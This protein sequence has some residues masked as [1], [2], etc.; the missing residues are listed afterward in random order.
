MTLKLKQ[1]RAEGPNVVLVGVDGRGPDE[2]ELAHALVSV[3]RDA[4]TADDS[5]FSRL[6]MRDR[7]AF[8]QYYER[9]AAVMV[10]TGPSPGGG[11]A[12]WFNPRARRQVETRGL[13]ALLGALA[14]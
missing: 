8:F 9:L 2:Q 10:R 5:Y 7:K 12:S 11:V 3:A 4:E 14:E 6:G 13:Q 1:L